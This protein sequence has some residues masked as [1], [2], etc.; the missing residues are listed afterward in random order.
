MAQHVGDSGS[1]DS[2]L[3]TRAA[4]L[5]GLGPL[6]AVVFWGISFVGIERAVAEISPIALI[7]GQAALGSFVLLGILGLGSSRSERP[8]SF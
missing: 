3:G 2:R 7:L 8:S 1:R 4:F 6:A 5:L